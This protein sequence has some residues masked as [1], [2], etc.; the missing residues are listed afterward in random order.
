MKFLYL[1]AI[2]IFV[3][4]PVFSAENLTKENIVKLENV[5]L[6]RLD[7]WVSD[8]GNVGHLQEKVVTNCGKL[9]YI[10][11][12]PNRISILSTEE[13]DKYDTLIDM[14]TKITVT[15]VYPQP[16]F[17][18][19]ENIEL[20]CTNVATEHPIFIKLCQKAKLIE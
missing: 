14:C 12:D 1:T 13:R 10:H 11:V 15:R 18:S 8:G 16:E 5:Y 2:S 4:Q 19:P 20:I 7:K 3:T 6:E 9:F 17:E